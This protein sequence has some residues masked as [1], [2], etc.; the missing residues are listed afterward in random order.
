V[1]VDYVDQ[2]RTQAANSNEPVDINRFFV[3]SADDQ[4]NF[5]KHGTILVP[6]RVMFFLVVLGLDRSLLPLF[7]FSLSLSLSLSLG[8]GR[9]LSTRAIKPLK[10]DASKI[11][12]WNADDVELPPFDELSHA[13]I[14]KWAI[15]KVNIRRRS[16]SI[17]FSIRLSLSLR[18]CE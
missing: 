6:G 2:C 17:P 4:E 16:Y 11:K 18:L 1:H 13:E 12:I 10:F 8:T 7:E 3:T 9:A 14:G 15:F 5:R